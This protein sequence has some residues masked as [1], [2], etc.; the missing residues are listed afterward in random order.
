[1][2]NRLPNSGLLNVGPGWGQ[3]QRPALRTHRGPGQLCSPEARPTPHLWLTSGAQER[4]FDTQTAVDML[5][6]LLL[7]F[8]D[9]FILNRPLVMCNDILVRNRFVQVLPG[10]DSSA[11]NEGPIVT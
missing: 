9:E 10:K 2:R 4:G 1:M 7:L 6:S 5:A 3:G 8:V 11:F